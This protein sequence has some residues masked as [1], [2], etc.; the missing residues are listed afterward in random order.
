[1]KVVNSPL[2]FAEVLDKEP[3]A[4]TVW[5]TYGTLSGA[6]FFVCRWRP[7][8]FALFGPANSFAAWASISELWDPYVGPEI[9]RES[10]PLFIQWHLAL[11]FALAGPV[12][13]FIVG[14][15]RH[16][17]GAGRRDSAG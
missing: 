16:K 17:R 6:G 8:C 12:A 11:V 4:L 2:F 10:P 14:L 13:G 3:T 7:W 5:L 9:L 1:M 15:R